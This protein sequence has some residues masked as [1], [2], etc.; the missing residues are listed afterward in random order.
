MKS[1]VLSNEHTL[2]EQ[3]LIQQHDQATRNK[4]NTLE[5]KLFGESNDKH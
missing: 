1:I 5:K 4:I 3:E 2:F